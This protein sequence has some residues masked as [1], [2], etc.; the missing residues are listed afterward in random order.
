[1]SVLPESSRRIPPSTLPTRLQQAR[2][3]RG[4]TQDDL[5]AV[6]D[7]SRGTISNYERG[8]G[9]KGISRLQVNAWAAFCDVDV[10]WLKTGREEGHPSGPGDVTVRYHGARK[11]HNWVQNVF[12]ATD[13]FVPTAART[14]QA[15]DQDRETTRVAEAA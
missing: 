2:E 8:V 9:K 4:Y 12:D 10:E 6:L 1:M 15:K 14:D 13:R 3:W 5:A 7:V 11:S